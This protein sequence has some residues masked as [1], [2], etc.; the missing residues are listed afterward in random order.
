MKDDISD[1]D[2][3]FTELKKKHEKYSE[4]EKIITEYISTYSKKNKDLFNL[5]EWV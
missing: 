1:L 3:V 4:K 2:D 5:L